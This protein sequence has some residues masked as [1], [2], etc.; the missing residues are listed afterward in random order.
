M[1]YGK[2]DPNVEIGFRLQRSQQIGDRGKEKASQP[3]QSQPQEATKSTENTP[4]PPPPNQEAS[5]NPAP[6]R[7]KRPSYPEAWVEGSDNSSSVFS[8]IPEPD[9]PIEKEME[10][11]KKRQEDNKVGLGF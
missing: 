3:S 7:K 11:G 5:K 8:D 10:K 1:H 4:K 2:E 9:R 6:I